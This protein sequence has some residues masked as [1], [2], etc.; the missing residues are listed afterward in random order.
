M[1]FEK[2]TINTKKKT[3]IFLNANVEKFKAAF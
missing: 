3:S 1:D 2:I